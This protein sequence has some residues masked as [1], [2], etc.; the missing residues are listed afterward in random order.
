GEKIGLKL[1]RLAEKKQVFSITHLAQV[2]AFAKTHIK[3]Y[4]E[5]KNSRTYTKA[6]ILS[7][8]EHIEEIARM[9]SG[10]NITPHALEHAKTLINSCKNK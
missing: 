4:K 5:T 2:S 10:E 7:E 6:K 8:A 9:I 3:I 1:A